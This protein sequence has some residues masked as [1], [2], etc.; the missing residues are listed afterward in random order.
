MLLMLICYIFFN[1][2]LSQTI[3]IFFIHLFIAY[4][5]Y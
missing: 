2:K 5:K 4:N 3:Y 1:D